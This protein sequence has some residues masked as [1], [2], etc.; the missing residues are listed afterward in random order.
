MSETVEC[1]SR[2]HLRRLPVTDGALSL[3]NGLFSSGLSTSTIGNVNSQR[4]LSKVQ[5]QTLERLEMQEC[6]LWDIM[7]M[8]LM[9]ASCWLFPFSSKAA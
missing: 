3:L 7:V 4:R 8:M 9:K 5:L 6:S 1:C 2:K